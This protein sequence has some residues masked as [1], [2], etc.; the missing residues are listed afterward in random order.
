MSNKPT[1]PEASGG[2]AGY[3]KPIMEGYIRK[4]GQ[5]ADPASNAVRPPPPPPFRPSPAPSAPAY[6]GNGATENQVNSDGGNGEK[7]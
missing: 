1:S 6:S 2:S 5:N 7:K 3:I 4:G